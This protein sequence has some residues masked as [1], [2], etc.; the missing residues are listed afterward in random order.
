M[1]C[2]LN[3]SCSRNPRRKRSKKNN[4]CGRRNCCVEVADV[5]KSYDWLSKAGLKDSTESLILAAQEQVLST[6]IN[7]GWGLPQ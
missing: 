5:K 1:T 4:H 2:L 3:T 7:G 6:K